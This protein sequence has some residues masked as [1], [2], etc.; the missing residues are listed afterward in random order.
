MLTI[1]LGA[2]EVAKFLEKEEH[3]KFLNLDSNGIT[4]VGWYSIYLALFYNTSLKHIQWYGRTRNLASN[5]DRPTKDCIAFGESMT[6]ENDTADLKSAM[7]MLRTSSTSLILSL[8]KT[9][10]TL[11]N[12]VRSTKARTKLLKDKTQE[13]TDTFYKQQEGKLFAV[14]N[15]IAS[16]LK[17]AESHSGMYIFYPFLLIYSRLC[18]RRYASF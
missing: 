5:T 2:S 9:S 15:D 10:S 3:L 11:M 6:T 16:R 1:I 12:K 13:E 17:A 4:H 8:G 18:I 7:S 14:L